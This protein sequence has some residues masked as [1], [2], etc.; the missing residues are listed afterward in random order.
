MNPYTNI[1]SNVCVIIASVYI[2]YAFLTRRMG[3]EFEESFRPI[4]VI[5][6]QLISIGYTGFI[7]LAIIAR[8]ITTALS[9]LLILSILIILTILNIRLVEPKSLLFDELLFL[10][11]RKFLSSD[12]MDE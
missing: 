6:F 10:S 8:D 7:V 11:M 2:L 1:F 12:D 9:Y 4:L 5:A 3:E